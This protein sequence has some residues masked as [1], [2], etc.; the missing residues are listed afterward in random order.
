MADLTG[1]CQ[2]LSFIGLGV[3]LLG[4]GR[5]TSGYYFHARVRAERSRRE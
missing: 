1:I 2:A 4:I 5:S 3:V